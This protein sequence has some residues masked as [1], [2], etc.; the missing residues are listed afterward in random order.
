MN[1][2]IWFLFPSFGISSLLSKMERDYCS[3]TVVIGKAKKV[4]SF[5]YS[6]LS[7]MRTRLIYF[8]NGFCEFLIFL[9]EAKNKNFRQ[10]IMSE[11]MRDE[12]REVLSSNEMSIAQRGHG[13]INTADRSSGFV[14]FTAEYR[15]R[16]SI[17][18]MKNVQNYA[19][20]IF[21]RFASKPKISEVLMARW[22][23]T[24]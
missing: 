2:A 11:G 12:N 9:L 8:V 13:S 4:L 23:S 7:K 1:D 3:T 19:N 22:S 24:G 5:E 14:N 15:F 18:L 10:A 21:Q 16:W 20:H 6:I 17:H